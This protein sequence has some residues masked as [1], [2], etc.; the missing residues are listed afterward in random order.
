MG[1]KK[2]PL[3]CLMLGGVDKVFQI[4]KVVCFYP[5]SSQ[6]KQIG[7]TKQCIFPKKEFNCPRQQYLKTWDRSSV[8]LRKHQ[9]CCLH[10]FQEFLV[11][12]IVSENTDKM[13]LSDC[14][15]TFAGT[16]MLVLLWFCLVL[17]WILQMFGNKIKIHTNFRFPTSDNVLRQ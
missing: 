5:N 12:A 11:V 15:L 13:N 2:N 1:K 16:Q 3:P 10:Q 14:K 8:L 17:S 4:W 7:C 9:L 6:T